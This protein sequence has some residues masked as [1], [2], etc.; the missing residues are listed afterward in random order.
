[1][2]TDKDE[3]TE[4]ALMSA[5]REGH[6]GGMSDKG[7]EILRRDN[8]SL[9]GRTPIIASTLRP[10]SFL[11]CYLDALNSCTNVLATTCAK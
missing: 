5:C 2:N 7:P 11:D 6:I 10:S 1:M 9:L 4:A 3:K 8:Y